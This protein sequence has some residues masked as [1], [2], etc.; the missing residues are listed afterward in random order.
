[1]RRCLP[2]VALG[3]LALV[4][5]LA[6][7]ST[8]TG[9]R[10][11]AF[12]V[13][14][15]G[16]ATTVAPGDPIRSGRFYVR[17][18]LGRQVQLDFTLPTQLARVGGGGTLAIT[19]QNGDAVAQQTAPGSPPTPFDPTKKKKIKLTDSADLFVNLGGRVSPTPT[20]ATG[21]YIGTVILTCTFL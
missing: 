18:I 19:F 11:L 12:G 5:P 9:V 7:Q 3:L 8:I 14:I 2:I 15:R 6:G 10:N 1:M 21:S 4:P 16:V 17:H 20:Q 13:V